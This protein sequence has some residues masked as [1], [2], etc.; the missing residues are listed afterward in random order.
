MS[1]FGWINFDCLTGKGKKKKKK[2]FKDIFSLSLSFAFQDWQTSLVAGK[3]K[4]SNVKKPQT[5]KV[6]S[7]STKSHGS[8]QVFGFFSPQMLYNGVSHVPY[9]QV[10]GLHLVSGVDSALFGKAP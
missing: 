5:N 9:I 4:Q 6:T 3:W 8:R 10:S 7:F 1:I 2:G